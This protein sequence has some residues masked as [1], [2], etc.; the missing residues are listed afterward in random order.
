VYPSGTVSGTV[1]PSGTTVIFQANASAIGVPPGTYTVPITFANTSA[2]LTGPP[3]PGTQTR[4]ATLTVQP[5]RLQFSC[6]PAGILGFTGNAG[7]P[8]SP[9]LYTCCQ[10]ELRWL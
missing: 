3:G 1:S 5:G 2:G 10:R 6:P 9:A 4:M 7:G 8:F